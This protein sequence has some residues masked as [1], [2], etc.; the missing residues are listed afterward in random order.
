MHIIV[1]KNTANNRVFNR[2]IEHVF[3]RVK[4]L[5]VSSIGHTTYLHLISLLLH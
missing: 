1:T 5:F 3:T 2:L 4:L